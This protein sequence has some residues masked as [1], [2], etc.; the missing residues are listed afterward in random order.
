M[1]NSVLSVVPNS[2]DG[3][4]QVDPDMDTSGGTRKRKSSDDVDDP[5]TVSQESP[6]SHLSGRKMFPKSVS[7]GQ[8]THSGLPWIISDCPSRI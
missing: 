5:G 4:T 8:G 6:S 3:T 2:V 1:D 7:A